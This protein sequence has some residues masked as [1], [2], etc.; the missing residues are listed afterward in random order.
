MLK[1]TI[2]KNE[3]QL[4]VLESNALPIAAKS[5]TDNVDE[6][7]FFLPVN[8]VVYMTRG[9]VNVYSNED[10][11]SA[12][13][14]E[15]FFVSSYSNIKIQK[16]LDKTSNDFESITFFIDHVALVNNLMSI[17]VDNSKITRPPFK[18]NSTSS[19]EVLNIL[20]DHFDT[21]SPL[22][23]IELEHLAGLKEQIME[24]VNARL[25]SSSPNRNDGFLSFLYNHI[26][27]N[28]TLEELASKY[29]LSTSSF[30]R[31]FVEK[32]GIS[33][34]KWIKDQRLHYA[35]CWLL[36]SQ[37]P[38][39][40]IYLS[41]GFEDISHFSREFK[42]KFGYSPSKTTAITATNIIK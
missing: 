32:L 19:Q 17:D 11:F 41:L 37:K 4:E 7:S 8:V 10:C 31:L 14:G 27:I 26:S 24:S 34:H 2:T 36:F 15:C 39:S 35:R 38:V 42:K 23:P 5:I 40:E 28:I 22:L 18:L 3:R 13:P 30:H 9:S 6:V 16:T 20:K 12:V 33:P 29:G 21:K 25:N 1:T